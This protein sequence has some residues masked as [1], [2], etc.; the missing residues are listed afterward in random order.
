MKLLFDENLSRKLVS[1]LTAE[2]PDS[3]HVSSIGLESADDDSVWDYAARNGL[4]IVSKDS[5][6]RQRSF[7]FGAPPK[8]IWIERGN[9]TTGD[10]TQLLRQ[11]APEIKEF[12]R[13]AEAA[14][15]V[16]A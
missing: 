12:D 16:L 14:L 13:S 15:L 9:C 8:V 7:L 3:T 2:F 11:R 10:I 5:D 4:V 6:F 1:Q